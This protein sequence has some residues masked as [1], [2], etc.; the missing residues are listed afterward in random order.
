MLNIFLSQEGSSLSL[1]KL[2]PAQPLEKKNVF[3]QIVSNEKENSKRKQATWHKNRL[4]RDLYGVGFCTTSFGS[5][6][7]K[8]IITVFDLNSSSLSLSL[9]SLNIL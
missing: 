2:I 9:Y 8:K 6:V 1:S 5:P 7:L 3:C 4:G